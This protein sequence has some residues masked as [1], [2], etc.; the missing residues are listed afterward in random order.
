L[1]SPAP[2]AATFESTTTFN[3]PSGGANVE[4]NRSSSESASHLDHPA[5]P[6]RKVQHLPYVAIFQSTFRPASRNL[7]RLFQ[8]IAYFRPPS[9]NPPTCR[10]TRLLAAS[11][12]VPT[13][14]RL[15]AP[16]Q[17]Q[18]TASY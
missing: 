9:P 15:T 2:S 12:R 13:P 18:P 6:N 7:H 8:T 10:V 16:T 1:P 4:P 3:R 14:N 11:S 17:N 5:Q